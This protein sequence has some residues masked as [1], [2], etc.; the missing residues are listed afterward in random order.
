M[1]IDTVVYYPVSTSETA[2]NLDD[3]IEYIIPELSYGTHTY[4]GS[5]VTGNTFNANLAG[6][7]NQQIF[8]QVN[9]NTCVGNQIGFV[10]VIGAPVVVGLSAQY[11]NSA[12]VD[13]IQRDPNYTHIQTTTPTKIT[14]ENV[15]TVSATNYSGTFV[16]LGGP[17]PNNEYFEFDPSLVTGG[18]SVITVTYSTIIEEYDPNPPFAQFK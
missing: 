8:Y 10:E 14:Y 5:F 15:M 12:G 11:C 3:L 6:I 2:A 18:Q 7:G 1:D 9:N 4:A 17:N 13:N 16:A